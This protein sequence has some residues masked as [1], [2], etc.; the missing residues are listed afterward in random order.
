MPN[1]NSERTKQ[2][3]FI[4]HPSADNSMLGKVHYVVRFQVLKAARIEMTLFWDVMSYS[5]V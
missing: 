4:T 3:R 1:P 5:L 2:Q